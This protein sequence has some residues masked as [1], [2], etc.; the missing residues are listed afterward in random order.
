M[1]SRLIPYFGAKAGG[2]LASIGSDLVDLAA[3]AAGC[4]DVP[5]MP[6]VQLLFEG[7]CGSCGFTLEAR[8]RG[9]KGRVTLNDAYGL[10]HNLAD[11]LSV[12]R[13]AQQLHRS[14][15]GVPFHELVYQRACRY[16]AEWQLSAETREVRTFEQV[17]LA[18]ACMIAWWMGRNGEAGTDREKDWRSLV[19]GVCLR[20]TS[21][22]GDPAVRWYEAVNSVPVWAGLLGERTTCLSRDV[23]EVLADVP[24]EPSTLI[25]LDPPY[26]HQTRGGARYVHD[27]T[28]A[29]GGMFEH[30][31]F[32]A[33][34]AARVHTKENAAVVI[35]YGGHERVGRL[36]PESDGFI[37][38]DLARV[39]RSA[40]ASSKDGVNQSEYPEVAVVKCARG[41]NAAG[42]LALIQ[43]IGGREVEHAET[44]DGLHGIA[45]GQGHSSEE[46]G[47]A[48]G[49]AGHAEGAVQAAGAD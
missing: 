37:H 10:V 27:V 7:M 6:A 2:K 13:A 26:L 21:S 11:V 33:E 24:D 49:D 48:G 15:L 40:A 12:P 28:D 18:A 42:V 1:I 43:R 19:D 4:V 20:W 25:Y 22:G 41:V 17:E 9:Y 8:R 46:P 23:L 31:D 44:S 35:S 16:L 14:L 36:Y 30:L 34:L 29:T 45:V 47:A 38:A 39:K 5:S 3:A 32:H